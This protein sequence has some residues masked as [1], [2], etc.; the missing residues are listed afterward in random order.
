MKNYLCIS[1][2]TPPSKCKG[3][4]LDG[5]PGSFQ[6]GLLLEKGRIQ[7]GKGGGETKVELLLFH[8]SIFCSKNIYM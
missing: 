4:S 2:P 5:H 1:V 3:N 6:Q 8:V 7:Q